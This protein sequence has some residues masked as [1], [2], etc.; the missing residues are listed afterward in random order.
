MK[1]PGLG[2]GLRLAPLSLFSFSFSPPPSRSHSLAFSPPFFIVACF[3]YE[4][5]AFF[6]KSLRGLGIMRR[7]PMKFFNLIKSSPPAIIISLQFTN[8]TKGEY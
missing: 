4:V 8:N 6:A 5:T 1:I 7:S 2:P 3:N